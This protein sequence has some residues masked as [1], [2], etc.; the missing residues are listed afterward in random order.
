[1]AWSITD[2]VVTV[3]PPEPGDAD[4]LVA[5]RDAEFERWLGP[6]SDAPEPLACIEQQGDV[7]GW[8]DFDT[9]REWLEPTEVN[10]G[11][12]LFSAHHGHGYATR[13]VMLLLHHL[14][15]R[16][17]F[18]TATVLIDPGN[19]RSLALAAR[20]GFGPRGLVGDQQLSARPVPSLMFT[21]GGRTLRPLGVGDLDRHLEAVDDEQIDRLWEPGQR[22]LWEAMTPQQQ[23]DHQRR[24]L[25]TAEE[26][27]GQG[28]KWSFA[29]D[30]HDRPYVAYVDVD[31]ANDNCPAGE[32]NISYAC[33]PTQREN[34]HVSAGV[35]MVCEFLRNHT[36]TRRA[37]L[38]IDRDNEASLRVA[39]S[40]GA[41]TAGSFADGHG[42][43]RVRHVLDL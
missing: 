17:D 38:V 1:M 10:V 29:L 41:A 31:L 34:G 19:V 6:G 12:H 30:A 2:G 15:L 4:V 16:T 39:R 20:C 21:A 8:V 35:R 40:V 33:D 18:G 25:T 43:T 28:P 24:F 9:G 23:R 36:A 13:A 7:V 42:S 27:F 3:R 37:H 32:A 5:G 14:A 26:T 11:Y 22:A